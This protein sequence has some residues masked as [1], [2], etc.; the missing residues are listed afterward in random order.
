MSSKPTLVSALEPA[1]HFK[2]GQW[3]TFD[4][5]PVTVEYEVAPVRVVSEEFANKLF[6]YKPTPLQIITPAVPNI[7]AQSSQPPPVPK[8]SIEHLW[9]ATDDSLLKSLVDKYPNN[10]ELIAECFNAIKSGEN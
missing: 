4:E 9:T 8:R 2:D 1:K 5:L 3:G 10:W 6:D 7:P